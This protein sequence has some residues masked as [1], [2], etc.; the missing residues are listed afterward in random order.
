[1]YVLI[2][3][4]VKMVV[5]FAESVLWKLVCQAFVIVIE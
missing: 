1:M 2:E 4:K 5:L 3:M